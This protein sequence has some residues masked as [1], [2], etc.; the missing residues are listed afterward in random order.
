MKK[1]SDLARETN[2]PILNGLAPWEYYKHD[3]LSKML[4]WQK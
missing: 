4:E 1:L 2:I 3:Y